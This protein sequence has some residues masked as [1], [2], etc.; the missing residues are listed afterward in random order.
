M[1]KCSECGTECVG[2]FC[3]QCG[4]S[5]SEEGGVQ[6]TAKEIMPEPSKDCNTPAE[7][8]APEEGIDQQPMAEGQGWQQETPEEKGSEKK[9][10]VIAAIV[11]AMII[12]LLATGVYF[13]VSLILNDSGGDREER[14]SEIEEYTETGSIQV[15]PE[16]GETEIGEWAPPF[17][18]HVWGLSETVQIELD[19]IVLDV[20]VPPN[21]IIQEEV[22]SCTALF[23]GEDD[24]EDWLTIQV[25]LRNMMESDFSE[26]FAK[27]SV[28][29]V[30]WHSEWAEV[31]D[32]REYADRHVGLMITHWDVGWDDGYTFTKISQYR[33]AILL[34]EI[35]FESVVG[36]EELFGPFG[37]MDSF[38]EII[39]SALVDILWEETRTVREHPGFDSPEEAVITF[40]EGLRD[41]NYLQ[42]TKAVSNHDRIGGNSAGDEVVN[43]VDRLNHIIETFQTAEFEISVE[44]YEFESLDILGFVP[45]EAIS[46]R[47]LHWAEAGRMTFTAEIA[48]V[49]R[50]V[51]RVVI[52]ELDGEKLM[53][54]VDVAEVDGK[55]KIFEFGGVLD[56]QL[57]HAGLTRGIIPF[58]FMQLRF[59]D[60]EFDLEAVLIPID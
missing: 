42:M 22:G 20:P 8:S 1:W 36:R 18:L 11:V 14:I 26:Y 15:I 50:V 60:D 28:I 34:T 45:P 46:E 2:N 5:P 57:S 13:A 4:G 21:T 16:E 37:F 55:W 53:F 51:S 33:T 27:E 38:G 41:L 10:C 47:H 29:N 49:D 52:F 48:E 23:F 9:G 17:N 40:L 32:V 3:G 59:L 56:V 39:E 54:I 31:L 7:Q 58:E 35:R 6:P 25:T 19:G 30:E 12:A 24:W 43:F 44:P